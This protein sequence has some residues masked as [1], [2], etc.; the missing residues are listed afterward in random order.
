MG[1]D[2]T[3]WVVAEDTVQDPDVLDPVT[4]TA[5]SRQYLKKL[6]QGFC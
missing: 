2:G 1:L 5:V 6:L 4:A 3:F